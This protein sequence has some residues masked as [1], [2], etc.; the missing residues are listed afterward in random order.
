MGGTTDTLLSITSSKNLAWATRVRSWVE[1]VEICTTIRYGTAA[2]IVTRAKRPLRPT[3]Y[4]HTA[5]KKSENIRFGR[6]DWGKTQLRNGTR[7]IYRGSLDLSQYTPK[8]EKSTGKNI[9]SRVPHSAL[10]A[11]S[12]RQQTVR[13]CVSLQMPQP[14]IPSGPR[15]TIRAIATY[16]S[17]NAPYK[18]KRHQPTAF[19]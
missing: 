16:V 11:K 9:I 5:R 17:A 19:I 6:T 12:A 13:R 8:R 10:A 18:K 2:H 7:D 3:P 1:G 15:Q 4:Q 14:R